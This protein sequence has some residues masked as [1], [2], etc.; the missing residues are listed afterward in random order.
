MFNPILI[1]AVDIG[2]PMA[3]R[4]G[5]AVLPSGET[6]TDI[7][8]LVLLVSE[9][10]KRGPVA[11]GFEAPFWIP[12]RSDPMTLTKARTGEG[13]RSWS[14][15][16]GA[17]A[18]ATG[19]V[20]ATHIL[21]ALKSA[22]PEAIATFDYHSPPTTPGGLFL[23]EAFV[24][25]RAKG[26]SHVSDAMIAAAAFMAATPDL[27]AAQKLAHETNFNLLGALLLRT[28]WAEDLGL[29]SQELLVIAG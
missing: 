15:G 13:S 23:W 8:R 20:V 17:G 4:L 14:A 25:G 6:G 26:D 11:L 21:S 16:A 19:L 12:I 7:G 3:G 5:W 27:G 18:L 1:A 10:L 28:G 22:A 2:S 9:A 29:M 24:T